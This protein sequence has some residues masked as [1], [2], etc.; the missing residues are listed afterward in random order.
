MAK[1][2]K[3]LRPFPYAADGVNVE[4]L[5]EGRVLS[6]PD[7]IFDGLSQGDEPYVQASDGEPENSVAQAAER[8]AA[9]DD[10]DRRLAGAS[11]QQLLEIIARSGKPY[12]GNLV[13]A[14]LVSLAK[15]QLQ[16][17]AE[18]RAPAQSVD[19][20]A[21]VTEQPLAR[22][23]EAPTNATKAAVASSGGAVLQNQFEEPQYDRMKK[24]DLENLAEQRGVKV[25]DGATKAEIVEALEK[26]DKAAKK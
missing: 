1:T 19:P 20:R 25:K 24:D 15:A 3:V 23:G 14:H 16:R 5:K 9:S 8:D 11:D 6:F 10:L 13:H 12:S 26:G 2:G 22:P 18:G 21:G 4:H 17:E 7:K